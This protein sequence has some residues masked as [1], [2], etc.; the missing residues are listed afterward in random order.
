MILKCQNCGNEFKTSHKNSKNCSRKCYAES[1]KGI[2]PPVFFTS[3]TAKKYGFKKGNKYGFKKGY[4]PWNKGKKTG[5]AP[6]KGKKHSRESILKIRENS[7]KGENSVHWKEDISYIGIHAWVVRTLGKPKKCSKCG[8]DEDKRYHWH[9]I[10][11]EYKREIDDWV[12]LCP[13]CHKSFHKIGE[14]VKLRISNSLKKYYE[15]KK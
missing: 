4:N 2:R 14:E 12:R 7:V 1:M 3:E 13:K 11:G 9:N 10:S 6:M 5:I 15:S 8:I